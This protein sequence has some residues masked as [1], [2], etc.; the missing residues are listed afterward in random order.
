MVTFIEARAFSIW[1]MVACLAVATITV[2]VVRPKKQPLLVAAGC[3]LVLAVTN[4]AMEALGSALDIYHLNGAWPIFNSPLSCNISWFCYGLLCS[5]GYQRLMR[6]GRSISWLL[7]FGLGAAL[8]GMA[9]DF[10]AIYGTGV[11]RLGEYGAPWMV[12][13]VWLAAAVVVAMLT[14]RFNASVRA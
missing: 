13:P 11:I 9:Y 3:G 1:F 12:P 6:R 2:A 4:L 5:L 14:R 10:F 8:L 7:G